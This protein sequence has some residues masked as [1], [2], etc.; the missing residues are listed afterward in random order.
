MQGLL[1]IETA[2]GRVRLVRWGPRTID[3][4]LLLF[5]DLVSEQPGITLPHPRMHER[6]FVLEPLATIA[7]EV[8]HPVL[9]RTVGE[10]LAGLDAAQP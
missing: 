9:G 7:A 1:D 6:R 10:L 5:D 2:M 8:R 4:D 3:L